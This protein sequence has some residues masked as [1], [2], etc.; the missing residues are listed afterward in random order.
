LVLSGFESGVTAASDILAVPEY[1]RVF[2]ALPS[3][4][5]AEITMAPP[6]QGLTT[7]T[8]NLI[9]AKGVERLAPLSAPSGGVESVLAVIP[10][11]GTVMRLPLGGT[12]EP[13]YIQRDTQLSAVAQWTPLIDLN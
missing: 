8:P 7:D 13:A 2:V 11:T 4:G 5:I 12:P 9:A 3:A 6:G 1:A 10:A